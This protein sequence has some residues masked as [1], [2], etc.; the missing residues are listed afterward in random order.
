M[1][2]L[3][4]KD[5]PTLFCFSKIQYTGAQFKYAM[6]PVLSFFFGSGLR[7]PLACSLLGGVVPIPEQR[8]G[9]TRLWPFLIR[10][11]CYY[12]P[13]TDDPVPFLSPPSE[14]PLHRAPCIQPIFPRVH[15]SLLLLPP[16]RP[17]V[18]YLPPPPPGAPIVTRRPPVRLT[19]GQCHAAPGCLSSVPMCDGLP[20]RPVRL[21]VLGSGVGEGRRR[22]CPPDDLEVLNAFSPYHRFSQT[23]LWRSWGGGGRQVTDKQTDR[24]QEE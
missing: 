19:G 2:S 10:I 22:Q 5:L 4:N 15:L 8:L 7:D 6:N 17:F 14:I 18:F 1:N 3:P 23:Y 11:V 13:Y 21:V 24:R 16:I 9:V 20:P 12:F